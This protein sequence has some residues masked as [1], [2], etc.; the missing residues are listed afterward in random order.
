MDPDRLLDELGRRVRERRNARGW[1]LRD[2]SER[3]GISLRFLVQL[4]SGS[5][6]ISVRRLVQLATALQT[7]ASALLAEEPGASRPTLIALLGLRG[8]GKTTIGRRLARRLRVRFVELDGRIEQLADLTLAEIFSLH[9]EDYYRRLEADALRQ[10]VDSGEPMVL[11]AGGGIVNT[12]ETFA[13][14]RRHALTIWLKATPEA[15]W[16]RVVKQ[17]DRRPMANHPQAMN[18]LRSLLASREPLYS[19]AAFTVDT[20]HLPPDEVVKAVERLVQSSR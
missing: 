17:G 6:N 10:V 13:L 2:L 20:S 18:A 19:A 5:G 8:A 9:G 15:H 16:N 1:T 4:E 3:S 12:S 7:S 11:A 14:L